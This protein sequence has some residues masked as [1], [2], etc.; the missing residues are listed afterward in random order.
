MASLQAE[1]TP[2]IVCLPPPL[3]APPSFP[4]LPFLPLSLSFPCCLIGTQHDAS[5]QGSYAGDATTSLGIHHRATVPPTA[6]PSRDPNGPLG[7][8]ARVRVGQP[9]GLQQEGRP[10]DEEKTCPGAQGTPKE[11]KSKSIIFG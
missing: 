11:L 6:V 7:Q 5:T 9:A 10:R 4:L 2:I 1:G 3:L 8:A